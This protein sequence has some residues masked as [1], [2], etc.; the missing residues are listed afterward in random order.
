MTALDPTC[1][2][3]GCR[4]S[5]DSEAKELRCPC[6]GGTYDHLG[7]VK[8]GPAARAAADG[9]P[10]RSTATKF[11]SKS[12]V[13]PEH[14][15]RLARLAYGLAHWPQEPPR[16]TNPGRCWLVVRHRQHSAAAADGAVRHG[17]RARDVL[18]ADA[19][20]RLRQHPLH[21]GAPRVR[22][23]A[24]RSALLRRQL[25]RR[26][27]RRAHAARRRAGLVQ[28]PARG[29]VDHRCRAPAA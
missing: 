22:A 14:V 29:D 19:R 28:E 27:R 4:V 20:S 12:D 25:H 7:V 21:H 24:A 2:H 15:A 16:R 1:T 5:W 3:L 9:W 13:A 10:R 18:R 6:H 23:R 8:G 17:R 11:S 26:R